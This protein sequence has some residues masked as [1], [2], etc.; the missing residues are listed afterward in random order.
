MAPDLKRA[1]NVS[2]TNDTKGLQETLFLNTFIGGSS[3]SNNSPL[4]LP[5]KCLKNGLIETLS[6]IHPRICACWGD[7]LSRAMYCQYSKWLCNSRARK[8]FGSRNNNSEIS[9]INSPLCILCNLTRSQAVTSALT[10]TGYRN[11]RPRT[12]EAQLLCL[13]IPEVEDQRSQISPNTTYFP[14][15]KGSSEDTLKH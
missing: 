5:L 8:Q 13:V 15:K 4:K 6:L 7:E 14:R 11:N 12:L 3:E 9:P 2:S 1:T 10:L